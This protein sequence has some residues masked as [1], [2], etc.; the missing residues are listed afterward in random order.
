MNTA[1]SDGSVSALRFQPPRGHVLISPDCVFDATL[2]PETC[3]DRFVD[4]REP[5]NKL[6]E[7]STKGEVKK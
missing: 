1:A 4:S 3:P 5:I 7:S 6:L 2:V